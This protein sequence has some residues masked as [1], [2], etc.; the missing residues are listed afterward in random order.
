[1][2]Q[3]NR[4]ELVA[5]K[6]RKRR[7]LKEVNVPLGIQEEPQDQREQELDAQLRNTE[8]QSEILAYQANR[9]KAKFRLSSELLCYLYKVRVRVRKN[10]VY[11]LMMENTFDPNNSIQK[12]K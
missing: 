4:A 12:V 10:N 7:L 11:K 3:S 2:V 5:L 1:M 6:R 9:L 8:W